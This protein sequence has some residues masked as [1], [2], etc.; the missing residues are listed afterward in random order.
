MFAVVGV[1]TPSWQMP[2]I[3]FPLFLLWIPVLLLSPILF[4]VLLAACIAVRTSFWRA[5][6]VF[7]GILCSLPGTDVRV[8]AD[9]NHVVVRIL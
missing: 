2:R 6:A 5:V 3:W 4:L 9:Q 1:Q 8:S 7:W